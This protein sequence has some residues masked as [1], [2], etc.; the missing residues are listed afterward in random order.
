MERI[1]GFDGTGVDDRVAYV[2]G[3]AAG[4]VEGH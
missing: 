2:T 1:Y 4:M 3:G